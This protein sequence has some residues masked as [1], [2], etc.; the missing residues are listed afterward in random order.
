MKNSAIQQL[1]IYVNSAVPLPNSSGNNVTYERRKSRFH[2]LSLSPDENLLN[3][4]SDFAKLQISIAEGT[5]EHWTTPRLVTMDKWMSI[6]HWSHYH[7]DRVGNERIAPQKI[8][9]ETCL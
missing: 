2:Q 7:L 3:R 6:T 9:D 5:T 4:T 1:E 8:A